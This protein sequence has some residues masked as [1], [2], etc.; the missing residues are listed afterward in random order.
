V[1]IGFVLKGIAYLSVDGLGLLSITPEEINTLFVKAVSRN[2][3]AIDM[4][5]EFNIQGAYLHR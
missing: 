2:D 3:S 4:D 1:R 5:W